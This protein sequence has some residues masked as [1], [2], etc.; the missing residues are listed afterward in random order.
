MLVYTCLYIYRS[1][2][3]GDQSVGLAVDTCY[4]FKVEFGGPEC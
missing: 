3:R 2:A 1:G 4:H